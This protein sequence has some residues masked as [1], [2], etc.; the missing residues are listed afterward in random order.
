METLPH[1]PEKKFENTSEELAFLRER[2][3]ALEE[4]HEKNKNSVEDTSNNTATFIERYKEAPIEKV[5]E[6]KHTISQEESE[7][8]VLKLAPEEHDETMAELLGL[9][10]EKGVKNTLTLVEKMQDEH[11]ADDFHRFL[12]EYLREGY[13]ASGIREGEP[14]WKALHMTLYEVSLPT[15]RKEDQERELRT[16]I[17][18]MEQFYA[19]MK[20]VSGEKERQH[21]TIEIAQDENDETV[22]FYV[23]VPSSKEDLFEKHI[24]STFSNARIH[25]HI[26]DYNIFN[27]DGASSVS[28][29]DTV[30][31]DLFPLKTYEQFDVDPLNVLLNSFSKLLPYGEGAAIQ[32][33]LRPLTEGGVK[34]YAQAIGDLQKGSSVKEITSGFGSDIGKKAYDLVQGIVLGRNSAKNKDAAPK[35]I[36]QIALE[37]AK[38]KIEGGAFFESIIRVVASAG[39][40]ARADMIRSEIE[41]AFHQFEEGGSNTLA[42]SVQT[43]RRQKEAVREFTY[44]LFEGAPTI[45][46]NIKELTTL[47]HFPASVI[48]G[49]TQLKRSKAGTA[50]VPITVAQEGTLLGLN[51]HRGQERKVFI[52]PEDRLRHFYT[53]GQ[54]GT[55]KTTLLKNM[56]IQDIHNGEGVCMIDPHGTDIADVLAAVPDERMDDV[57][58]FDPAYV[59]EPMGLNMLEY[60]EKFPEQKTF[61]VDELLSIFNKLFD[62]KTA[63][64]PMF[65]QYFRNAVLLVMDDPASGNTLVDV[66]RVLVDQKFRE[67]KLERSKNPIVVQ[68]WR[69]IAD[70]AGGEAS[71][72]NI[73]PYITSKFDI[74]L[75][76]EVMRP[77]IGQQ[78]SAF[79]FRNIMDERKILL[80]NLSK[81][82]LGD[83]NAHL[84]GLILVGKILM[85]ALSRADSI[86]SD[87]PPF[88]LYI[89]EFQNV[90]TDSISKILSE[91]RKYKLSLNIAHQFIAQ[92]DPKIKDAVFGNVGSMAT[93]RVGPE[94]AEFLENQFSPPFTAYDIMN[95]DNHNAYVRM[96]MNGQPT[97]PFNIST[98]PPEPADVSRI[99]KL[100]ELSHQKYGRP[101][102]EVEAEIMARYQKNSE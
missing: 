36:D 94:D 2:L 7:A 73:V 25:Q 60:D 87:M 96:L 9:L 20:S 65:E 62:M 89:D 47:M 79:N 12:I 69:E 63:G 57:I 46:L 33:L 31:F 4:S 34:K 8:I 102:A 10:Q 3:S 29:A 75:S 68:F 58:Y 19:G 52:T 44:R 45:D 53:I 42:F 82:R 77:V 14:L 49:A 51:S 74:F 17:S 93:F 55:G 43:G 86:G 32:I 39:T 40:Q 76:N 71:L 13:P 66:S 64:G 35:E 100:K 56:I 15:I 30:A 98:Y 41:S 27:A 11:I 54:T 78:T 18:S 101:R 1:I 16:L 37:R 22:V 90:T 24:L 88:Y 95:L 38:K 67:L 26:N 85:A 72:Q 84:I 83:I 91:A 70:K 99:E 48:K 6:S 80:V 59:Q 81:G 5:L 23:A 97:E 50:P 92:I 61:V 28:V 21:F